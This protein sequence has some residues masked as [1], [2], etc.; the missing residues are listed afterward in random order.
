MPIVRL[1]PT[2]CYICLFSRESLRCPAMPQEN[3]TSTQHNLFI[4]N[5]F[6]LIRL[7]IGSCQGPCCVNIFPF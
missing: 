2:I 1:F 6:N 3:H 4:K 5:S 7:E